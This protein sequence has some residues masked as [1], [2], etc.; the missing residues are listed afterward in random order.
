MRYILESP[1]GLERVN[2]YRTFI[3]KAVRDTIATA[4]RNTPVVYTI[5][6]SIP[7]KFEGWNSHLVYMNSKVTP[8]IGRLEL[9]T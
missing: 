5:P 6:S 1:L 2:V 7:G 4:K 3:L 8:K 9:L